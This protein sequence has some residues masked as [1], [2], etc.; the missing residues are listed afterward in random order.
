[1]QSALDL[2]MQ[3]QTFHWDKEKLMAELPIQPGCS[4]TF[5][6]K[7]QATADFLSPEIDGSHYR[8][9]FYYFLTLRFLLKK[10][11]YFGSDGSLM[12]GAR[13]GSQP[14]SLSGFGHT[15]LPSRLS[16]PALSRKQTSS[17]RTDLSSASFR[18]TGS[19]SRSGS[20]SMRLP[21]SPISKLTLPYSSKVISNQPIQC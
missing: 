16:S 4:I 8:T 10:K 13:G 18:S 12:N 19:S 20:S 21:P 2:D 1:M 14:N 3:A 17:R 9:F 15:S 5:P 11:N 6:L 7:I